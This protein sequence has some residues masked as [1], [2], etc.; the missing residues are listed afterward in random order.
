MSFWSLLL[1]RD[2]RNHISSYLDQDNEWYPVINYK[3][4][5]IKYV[6]KKYDKN[7]VI[8]YMTNLQILDMQFS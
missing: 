5:L 7:N 4:Y 8:K 6:A 2:V 1:P 3:K